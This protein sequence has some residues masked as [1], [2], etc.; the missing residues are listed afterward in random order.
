MKLVTCLRGEV[1]DVAVDL[2]RGS[3]T[4]LQWHGERL[5]SENNR[6]LLIPEG[7]AHGFQA[8]TDAVEL[9]YCHSTPYQPHAEAGLHPNDPRLSIAWPQEIA[10]LSPRDGGHPVLT[11]DF[12]GVDV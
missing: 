3:P 10:D 11:P 9:L 7:F 12:R 8:L 6:A 5:S 2:R 1:F 4:F